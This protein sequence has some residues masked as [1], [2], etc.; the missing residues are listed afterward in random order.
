MKYQTIQGQVD[1]TTGLV[2]FNTSRWRIYY[3]S[4]SN[5]T[6]FDQLIF[7]MNQHIAN[8][9]V[10]TV[11]Y[12][13]AVLVAVRMLIDVSMFFKSRTDHRQRFTNSVSVASIIWVTST[14]T[15]SVT[16]TVAVVETVSDA[17]WF[18]RIMSFIVSQLAYN[19][20]SCRSCAC[21][22]RLRC[23]YGV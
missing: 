22:C 1:L 13:V 18:L 23:H 9:V 8:L 4:R 14:M 3:I 12:I 19:S 10:D 16:N 21:R 2:A 6:K 17:Y 5:C 7:E 20:D 15:V 11:E